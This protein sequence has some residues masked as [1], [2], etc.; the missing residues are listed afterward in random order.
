M[1]SHLGFS[2]QHADLHQ[3]KDY[4][5]IPNNAKSLELVTN[6]PCR[7]PRSACDAYRHRRRRPMCVAVRM[8]A[9]GNGFGSRATHGP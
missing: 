6:P 9:S 3:R 8:T 1:Y 2:C 4:E 5:P 7:V